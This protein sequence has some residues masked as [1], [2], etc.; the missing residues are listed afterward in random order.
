MVPLSRRLTDLSIEQVQRWVMSLLVLA[1]ASFP[2]GALAATSIV[3]HPDGRQ[4]KAVLIVIMMAALGCVA[5][6]IVRKIH[7]RSPLSAWLI[8]GI[9]PAVTTAFFVLG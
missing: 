3:L 6:G 9:A 5:V 8:V 7:E 2:K 4:D 1:V